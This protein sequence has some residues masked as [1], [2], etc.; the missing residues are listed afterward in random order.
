MKKSIP[1]QVNPKIELHARTNSQNLTEYVLS[2]LTNSRIDIFLLFHSFD[3]PSEINYFH[4]KFDNMRLEHTRLAVGFYEFDSSDRVLLRMGKFSDSR[5]LNKKMLESIMDLKGEILNLDW[6]EN[7]HKLVI[8]FVYEPYI[9]KYVSPRK[10]LGDFFANNDPVGK[11]LK[12]TN[13][14]FVKKIVKD[15]RLNKQNI[16]EILNEDFFSSHISDMNRLAYFKELY[17][18]KRNLFSS[19]DAY[20][21]SRVEKRFAD[22]FQSLFLKYTP[23]VYKTYTKDN[24]LSAPRLKSEQNLE[25]KF[26]R[27]LYASEDDF[28]EPTRNL[29]LR[30]AEF[31]STTKYGYVWLEEL[32]SEASFERVL[33]IHL[34]AK[35]LVESFQAEC[36]EFTIR[37]AKM[38]R[39][40]WGSKWIVSVLTDK[41]I[42]ESEIKLPRNYTA[43]LLE[44]FTHYTYEQTKQQL[45][46]IDLRT[47]HSNSHANEFLITEPV[48]FSV[49]PGGRFGSS[50]LGNAGIETFKKVHM[51]NPLCKKFR[52]S[53][54][55]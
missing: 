46:I 15:N 54:W 6:K 1:D 43:E 33:D 42:H 48:I 32:D 35:C 16:D 52:L 8:S 29:F 45:M 12:Y 49:M 23:V 27:D 31:K 47:L 41:E 51:C 18:L 28:L 4:S 24:A 30:C 11:L 55:I 39:L 37:I 40:V 25:I 3:L 5:F 34:T 14:H 2:M 17:F 10:N 7:H 13:V 50:D 19:F 44:C 38:S 53:R 9:L 36:P 20:K 21:K 26:K 22:Q